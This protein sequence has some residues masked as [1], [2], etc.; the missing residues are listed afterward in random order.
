M[1]VGGTYHFEIKPANGAG[2]GYFDIAY[3]RPWESAS[4]VMN[5]YKIPINVLA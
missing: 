2:T 5:R 3:Y 1:G 4:S